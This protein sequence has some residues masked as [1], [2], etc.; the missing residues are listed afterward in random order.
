MIQNYKTFDEIYK[1]PAVPD[2]RDSNNSVQAAMT[3]GSFLYGN[4]N[5]LQNNVQAA[6]G[7][8][9]KKST[10]TKGQKVYSNNKNMA[11]TATQFN[12]QK[13]TN[14]TLSRQN[15]L[16]ATSPFAQTSFPQ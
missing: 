14:N 15:N 13:L 1:K 3:M 12:K 7:N 6:S 2:Y 8:K 9:V 4:N 5:R 10:S 16:T 11:K